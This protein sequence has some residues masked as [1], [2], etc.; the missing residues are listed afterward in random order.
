M[1]NFGTDFGY[2]YGLFKD[3]WYNF[4]VNSLDTNSFIGAMN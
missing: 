3:M 2:H 1:L 4:M